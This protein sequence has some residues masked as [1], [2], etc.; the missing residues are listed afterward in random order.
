MSNQILMV[1]C[2]MP[3]G[4]VPAS[5]A[6]TVVEEKLAACAN[7]VPAVRSIYRWKGEVCDDSEV[8]AILKTTDDRFEALRARLVELHPYDCPE[9]LAVPVAKGHEDYLRWVVEQSR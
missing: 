8:L 3:E 9:V 4:D 7:L 5:I 1:Y 6:R 2:T